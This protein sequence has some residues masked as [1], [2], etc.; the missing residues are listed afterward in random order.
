MLHHRVLAASLCVCACAA[1]AADPS[2]ASSAVDKLARSGEV[3]C[4]PRLPYFCSNLHVACAGQTSIKAFAFKLKANGSRG[5]IES[6]ADPDDVL[7]SY[8]NGRVE[9]DR[10]GAY[11]I[12]L[13]SQGSGYI[14]LLSDGSYSFRHHAPHGAVMSMGRCS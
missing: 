12:L 8:G 1:S 7:V 10:D 4:Q 9:W 5:S 13:P 6:A 11:A 14:K 2:A 3:A